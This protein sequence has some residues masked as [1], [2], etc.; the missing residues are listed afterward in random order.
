MVFVCRDFLRE[1]HNA[2]VGSFSLDPEDIKSLGMGAVWI[3][4]KGTGAPELISD[5]GAQWPFYRAYG[6]RDRKDSNPNANQSINK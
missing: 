2:Y 5:Y 6:N 1:K 3:F 4:S